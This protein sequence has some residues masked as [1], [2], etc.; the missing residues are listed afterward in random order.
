MFKQLTLRQFRKLT[1]DLKGRWLPENS[2]GLEF[3]VGTVGVYN[4]SHYL[5]YS[6]FGCH[7]VVRSNDP[8]NTCGW[9]GLPEGW[10]VTP[11]RLFI[12][13]VPKEKFTL[14]RW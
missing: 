13:K 3:P 5:E 11:G 14:V 8:N 7:K 12:L 10:I 1:S 6:H 2:S 4:D 9:S